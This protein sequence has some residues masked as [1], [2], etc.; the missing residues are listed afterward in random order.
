MTQSPNPQRLDRFGIRGLAWS[1]ADSARPLLTRK[2]RSWVCAK[3]GAGDLE[4]AI[5]EL[6]TCHAEVRAEISTALS[7]TVRSWLLGYSG[8]EFGRIV[9]EL[10][11][12]IPV[13]AQPDF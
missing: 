6:L 5:L 9:Q 2:E 1:L 11:D 13:A 8:T 3:I 12:R 4:D 10:V 7:M